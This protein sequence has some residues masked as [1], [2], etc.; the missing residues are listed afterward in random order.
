LNSSQLK[1]LAATTAADDDDEVAFC[2]HWVCMV[3]GGQVYVCLSR[4]HHKVGD[5]FHSPGPSENVYK[6]ASYGFGTHMLFCDRF[7]SIVIDGN[8]NVLHQ[9]QQQ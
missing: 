4:E 3:L 2:T 7:V 8:R 5:Y 1:F 6:L 9:W